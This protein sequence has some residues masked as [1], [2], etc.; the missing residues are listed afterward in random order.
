MSDISPLVVIIFMAAVVAVTAT[1]TVYLKPE[2][3]VVKQL[4]SRERV[5]MSRSWDG[6][7]EYRLEIWGCG[8][9]GCWY[10][11]AGEYQGNDECSACLPSKTR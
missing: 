9:G 6:D 2:T 3:C 1:I 4:G 10:L 8:D 11:D 5:V 7:I